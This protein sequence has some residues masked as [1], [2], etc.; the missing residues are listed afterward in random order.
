MNSEAH[1]QV[2]GDTYHTMCTSVSSKPYFCLFLPVSKEG[3]KATWWYSKPALLNSSSSSECWE[4]ISPSLKEAS[5]SW[6]WSRLYVSYTHRDVKATSEKVVALQG[7][8][9]VFTWLQSQGYFHYSGIFHMHC[10]QFHKNSFLFLW[11]NIFQ[12]FYKL[13]NAFFRQPTLVSVV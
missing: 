8:N 1:I 12:T 3:W 13:W 5:T 4:A 11:L 10:G 6:T 2:S 9:A 7:R